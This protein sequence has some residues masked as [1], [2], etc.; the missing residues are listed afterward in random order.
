MLRSISWACLWGALRDI[1]VN[2]LIDR[3][4]E[5]F[6]KTEMRKPHAGSTPE[7]SFPELFLPHERGSLLTKVAMFEIVFSM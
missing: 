4:K 3:K 7:F 2:C 1:L 6:G 5:H